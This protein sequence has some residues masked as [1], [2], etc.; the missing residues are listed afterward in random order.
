MLIPFFQVSAVKMEPDKLTVET[1][2]EQK[3]LGPRQIR[4]IKMQSLRGRYGR[5]T[6]IVNII[7]I[8]GKNYPL[9][10]FADGEEILYGSLM[11]WWNTYQKP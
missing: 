11:N 3:E 7:P 6:N 4:E 1:F 5:V 10:G 8:Q 9:G 2:F